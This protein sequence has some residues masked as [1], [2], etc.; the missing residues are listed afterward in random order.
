MEEI[1]AEARRSGAT[2]REVDTTGKSPRQSAEEIG[3]IMQSEGLCIVRDLKI[4]E[5]MREKL[6]EPLGVL[7]KDMEKAARYLRGT[8]IISV[9]DHV[10]YSLYEMGVKPR[11]FVTD[12]LVRRKPFEKKIEFDYLK[13][14][15][16]NPAG[17]ITRDLWMAVERA[18]K[19]G[20]PVRIVVDGEEDMAA[21][22]CMILAGKGMSVVYGLFDRGV[23]AIKSGPDMRRKG[24]ELLRGI[25]SHQ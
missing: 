2:V 9:G 4:P 13:I 22:P 20:R 7:F 10:S 18:L 24:V 25:A 21:L 3:E 6:R 5:H 16:K 15:A 14:G 11:F 12:G 23:C 1:L 19:S 8:E 17:Y